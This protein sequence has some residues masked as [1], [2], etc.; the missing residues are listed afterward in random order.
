[1]KD[2]LFFGSFI[3]E[4][5]LDRHMTILELARALEISNPY[6]CDIEKGNRNP[7]DFEKL[8]KLAALLE[9]TPEEKGVMMDLAG[10]YREQAAPDLSAWILATPGL[11]TALRT[12]RDM[13][14]S[15]DEWLEMVEE[16]KRRKGL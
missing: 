8:E 1:M 11:S 5:R 2:E 6:W 10:S 9:L 15:P 7:P 12:A 14:V 4:K 16:M 13:D 3:S